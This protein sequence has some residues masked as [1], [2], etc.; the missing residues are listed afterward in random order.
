MWDRLRGLPIPVLVLAG[1]GDRKF[2]AL[3]ERLAATVGPSARFVTIA[4][5]GHAVHL[6]QPDRFVSTLR[7]WLA[8]A[9]TP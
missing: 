4:G 2:T 3:G 6:E 5:A 8:E 7:S 9:F 1:E